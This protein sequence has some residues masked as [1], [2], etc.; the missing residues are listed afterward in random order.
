V[1][2]IVGLPIEK[3]DDVIAIRESFEVVKFVLED[4]TVQVA[5]ESDVERTGE[6]SKNI[7]GLVFAVVS[8]ATL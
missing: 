2:V 4:P 3:A 7:D 6:T 5:A 1:N 8:H